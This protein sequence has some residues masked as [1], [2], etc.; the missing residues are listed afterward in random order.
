MSC[1]TRWLTIA[2]RDAGLIAGTTGLRNPVGRGPLS[3]FVATMYRILGRNM[4]VKD[5]RR[6]ATHPPRAVPELQA[7][8]RVRS[9]AGTS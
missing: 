4:Q 8:G 6:Q 7:T 3:V 9:T 5:R 2:D 1:L